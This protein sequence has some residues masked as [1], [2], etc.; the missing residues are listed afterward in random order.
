VRITDSLGSPSLTR[1]YD[2]WGNQ[3]QGSSTSGYAFTGRE[4]DAETG[5]YY[6]RERYYSPTIARFLSQDPLGPQVGKSLYE[7]ASAN[8]VSRSDPWGLQDRYVVWDQFLDW[9][10]DVAPPQFWGESKECVSLVKALAHAPQTSQWRKGEDVWR[11]DS[12]VRG[13]AIATFG[14]DGRYSQDPNDRKKN[15]GIFVWQTPKYMVILDQWPPDHRGALRSVY[16]G[17]PHAWP[18]DDAK[19]YSVI[20]CAACRQ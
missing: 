3:L 16:T 2:P 6:Y 13:T 7:Y 14:P 8:P 11:N 19:A 4:S 1:A 18:E 5:L 20:T 15:S 12:V 9:V 17:P 10:L